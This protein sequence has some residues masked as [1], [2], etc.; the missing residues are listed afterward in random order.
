MIYMLWKEWIPQKFYQ[1]IWKEKSFLYLNGKN[2]LQPKVPE[3]RTDFLKEGDKNYK[4]LRN[5]LS[6]YK[7]IFQCVYSNVFP[8]IYCSTEKTYQYKK[9]LEGHQEKNPYKYEEI[10]NETCLYEHKPL[11]IDEFNDSEEKEVKEHLKKGRLPK[12]TNF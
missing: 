2:V 8:E 4:D 12:I 7:S 9:K 3:I 5:N 10:R 11:E 1:H 6:H